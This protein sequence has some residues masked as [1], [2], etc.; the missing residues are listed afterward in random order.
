MKVLLTGASGMCGGVIAGYL[1]RNGYDVVGTYRSNIPKGDFKAVFC[2]LS[3]RIDIE[4]DFDIIIHC[5]GTL[6][7]QNPTIQEY[8]SGNIDTMRNL[9]DYAHKKNIGRMIYIS[10]IGIYG[11]FIGELVD[12]ESPRVNP[13]NYGLTKYIAEKLLKEDPLVKGISLR[14]PGIIGKGA[15]GV[16]LSSVAEKMLKDEV[17]TITTP[18]FITRN[19]VHVNDL[20]RFVELLA[21]KNEWNH[22][23]LVLACE[24]GEKIKQIVAM[25]KTRLNSKSEICIGPEIRKPFCLSANRA[26]EMGYSPMSVDEMIKGYSKELIK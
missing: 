6:P 3:K 7:Y 17:V 13:D 15:R 21:K 1:Y 2:D 25:M 22:T 26:I 11:E 23:E 18:Q 8:V 5:A 24:S 16:W 4:L 20:A 12:E 10:T 14:C 9:L 19:F